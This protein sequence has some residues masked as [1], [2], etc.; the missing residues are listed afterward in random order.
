MISTGST[1]L[2]DQSKRWSRKALYA[3]SAAF[4][5]NRNINNKSETNTLR[6]ELPASSRSSR[7]RSI[8]VNDSKRLMQAHYSAPLRAAPMLGWIYPF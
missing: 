4:P 8:E 3:V 5:P 1:V 7:L 6:G 2:S